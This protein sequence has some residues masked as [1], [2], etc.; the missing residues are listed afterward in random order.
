MRTIGLL[1]VEAWVIFCSLQ[2]E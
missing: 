1:F 2:R